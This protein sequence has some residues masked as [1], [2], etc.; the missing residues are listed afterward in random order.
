MTKNRKAKSA[1]RAI[2]AGGTPYVQARRELNLPA[3]ALAGA[4]DAALAGRRV[5]VEIIDGMQDDP[6]YSGAIA[7]LSK[8]VSF[9]VYSDTK[10]R[11][12]LSTFGPGTEGFM[13]YEVLLYAFPTAF[14]RGIEYPVDTARPFDQID[15]LTGRA[16]PTSRKIMSPYELGGTGLRDFCWYPS[17]HPVLAITSET[18]TSATPM[19]QALA[20]EAA[21]RGVPIVDPG[22]ILPESFGARTEIYDLV[23]S[24]VIIDEH[25]PDQGFDD[26][27]K[28][29]TE[30]GHIFAVGTL[31]QIEQDPS[32]LHV[33]LNHRGSHDR[34]IPSRIAQVANTR[35]TID[36]KGFTAW[37]TTDPERALLHHR[38]TTLVD[39]AMA[40][41]FDAIV[42][43]KKVG[44][45]VEG[46]TF[47]DPAYTSKLA[48]LRMHADVGSNPRA[49]VLFSA[50]VPTEHTLEPLVTGPTSRAFDQLDE[51]MARQTPGEILPGDLDRVT[52]PVGD[53][54]ALALALHHATHP[55]VRIN[56]HT[57]DGQLDDLELAL[58]TR[59]DITVIVR[60]AQV[61]ADR[62]LLGR[63]LND[64][65]HVIFVVDVEQTDTIPVSEHAADRLRLHNRVSSLD[66]RLMVITRRD[67]RRATISVPA[68]PYAQPDVTK[69][70]WRIVEKAAAEARAE[71]LLGALDGASEVKLAGRWWTLRGFSPSRRYAVATATIRGEDSY[72]LL[73]LIEGKR[74]ADNL[75][76]GHGWVKDDEI[77]DGLVQL[78][79]GQV[80]LSY[81]NS[82][83]LE[84]QKTH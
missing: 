62:P 23:P 75:I 13:G 84:I 8:H 78:D 61:M 57:P 14:S 35:G 2:A 71:S 48:T 52:V 44:L 36:G 27:T 59:P 20:V 64:H 6:R 34:T 56:T 9:Y 69:K 51:I 10:K 4:Y 19:L 3:Q 81:R 60:D 74:G 72:T 70:G 79:T 45:L 76:F 50:G 33:H 12:L 21:W 43:G 32:V 49:D 39:R 66:D 58:T 77:A 63:L 15:H 22:G 47:R 28:R 37:T 65:Q 55:L 82:I 46:E 5:A 53:Q 40:S 18:Y 25:N 31:G 1:A 24:L 17:L 42:A 67:L 7:H 16:R 54:P 68:V 29:S 26:L 80:S 11:T 41:A 73:D 30:R 83:A 38:D